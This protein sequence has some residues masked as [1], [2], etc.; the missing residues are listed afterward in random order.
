[1]K[2]NTTSDLLRVGGVK[3]TMA[4]E[5]CNVSQRDLVDKIGCDQ[6]AV[7]NALNGKESIKVQQKIA[8]VLDMDVDSLYNLSIADYINVCKWRWHKDEN[9]KMF[10]LCTLCSLVALTLSGCISSAFVSFVFT[11]FALIFL[12]IGSF[13]V[14]NLWSKQGFYTQK[15]KNVLIVGIIVL[16]AINL[17]LALI[18]M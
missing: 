15:E 10:A 7:S 17:L 18:Q 2:L 6:S 11:S 5:R 12:A 8:R 4:C 1:M 13:F 3:L 16:L 9:L 14:R